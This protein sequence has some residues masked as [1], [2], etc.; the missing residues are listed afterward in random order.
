MAK[1]SDFVSKMKGRIGEIPMRTFTRLCSSRRKQGIKLILNLFI[2]RYGLECDKSEKW[3]NTVTARPAGAVV[4]RKG[5]VHGSVAVLP[6]ICTGIDN[7]QGPVLMRWCC[8]ILL[9]KHCGNYSRKVLF[10]S[11][12]SKQISSSRSNAIGEKCQ[13]VLFGCSC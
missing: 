6:Q 1:S 12:L 11:N 5:Q 3:W 7:L 9:L 10:T 8:L 13:K 4:K 2:T